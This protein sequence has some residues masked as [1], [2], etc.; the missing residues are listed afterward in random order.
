MAVITVLKKMM[1]D[2]TAAT[3]I[4]YGLIISLIVLGI[5]GALNQLAGSTIGMWDHVSSTVQQ[6]VE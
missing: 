3:A 1:R 4:E 6:N 5:V 2:Q